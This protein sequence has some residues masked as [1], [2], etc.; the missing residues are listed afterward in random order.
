MPIGLCQPSSVAFR[1][2]LELAMPIPTSMKRAGVGQSVDST[3]PVNKNN[4]SS[5]PSNAPIAASR[6]SAAGPVTGLDP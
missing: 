1:A 3:P 2:L 4:N 6:S 5:M